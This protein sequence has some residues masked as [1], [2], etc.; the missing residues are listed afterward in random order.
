M[1]DCLSLG[2]GAS[3]VCLPISVEAKV[4]RP[5]S[6]PTPVYLVTYLHSYLITYLGAA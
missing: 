6:Q 4:L 2:R 3:L 1:S 5:F